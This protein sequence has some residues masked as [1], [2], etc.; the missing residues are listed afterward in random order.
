MPKLKYKGATVQF[1]RIKA[2]KAPKI[3]EVELTP[4]E[5]AELE[6]KAF[7]EEKM[8]EALAEK[9]PE[10]QL[11][12]DLEGDENLL[13]QQYW[14]K[15]I[16]DQF[17]L[18]AGDENDRWNSLRNKFSLKQEYEIF[19]E[20]DGL[21]HEDAEFLVL[22]VSLPML[23]RGHAVMLQ[24][25]DDVLTLRVPNLYKLQLS[26]PSPIEHNSAQSFFDCKI[27]KLIIVAPVAKPKVEEIEEDQMDAE[28]IPATVPVQRI[29]EEEEKKEAKVE[30]VIQDDAGEEANDL[31]FDLV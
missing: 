21:N 8:K 13:T 27:R 22:V 15:V 10:W 9:K 17:E 5:R 11:Y 16:D 14:T 23:V 19:E 30:T 4:E 7:E 28:Q 26:L 25:L 1:Q 2:K 12:Y 29:E 6:R 3:Q 31:L 24:V 18:I 20:F